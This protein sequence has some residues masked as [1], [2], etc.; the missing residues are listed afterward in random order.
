MA[1]P[2]NTV[3]PAITGTVVVGQTLS[4]SNGTWTDDGSP[5]FT[6]AWL[7]DG[8]V[9]PGAS[10]NVYVLALADIGALIAGRVTDTDTGG[11]TSATS[12]ATTAVPSTLTPEDG[13]VVPDADSYVTIAYADAYH[14]ARGNVAWAA[15]TAADKEAAL[16]KATDHMGQTYRALWKGYRK[17]ATQT[18][19]WPRME[20]YLEP[21]VYGALGDYPYLVSNTIVPEEVKRA[22]AE[23]ALRVSAG[24]V[25][26]PDLTRAK[27]A[28][29]VGEISV[30]YD[31][32]SSEYP[33]FRSVDAVLAPYLT[34]SAF[35]AKVMRA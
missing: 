4:L 8:V 7:R 25:L 19:D 6:Y 27:S 10:S 11:A 3:L 32:A 14:S 23:L 30:T 35:N 2:V 26:S 28:V 17:D 31:D 34:G 21:F 13:T 33:R 24:T 16:R 22:C 18:L 5:A 1:A 9:I 29:S 15:K 12:S 20:V